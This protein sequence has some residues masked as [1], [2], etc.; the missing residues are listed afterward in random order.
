MKKALKIILSSVSGVIIF[1]IMLPILLSIMLQISAVQNFVVAKVSAKLS[2]IANTKISI[3]HVDIEF[4]T[5]AVLDDIYIQDHR[6]DTMIY[7]KNLKVAINGISFLSGKISLG[8]TTLNGGKVYLYK[9]SSG[10]MNVTE[11]FDNFK[12]TTPNENPPNFRLTATELNLLHTRFKYTD[13]TGEDVDYGIDFKAMD[14]ENITLQAHDI[15]VFNYNIWL[16]MKHLSLNEASGFELDHLSAGRCGVDSSGMYYARVAVETPN[17]TLALDSM[18]FLTINRSWWDWNDFE[19]KMVLS[20]KVRKSHISSQTIGYFTHKQLAHPIEGDLQGALL[21]GPVANMKGVIENLTSGSASVSAQFHIAGL[22]AIDSTVFRVAIEPLKIASNELAPM[23]RKVTGDSLSPIVVSAIE[24]L[25]EVSLV[26]SFD[27]TLHR[28][29]A[30]A[31]LHTAAGQVVATTDM[32]PHGHGQ[33]MRAIVSTTDFELGQM[34]N[35]KKLGKLSLTS[36]VDMLVTPQSPIAFNTQSEIGRIHYGAYDFKRIAINGSFIKQVFKGSVASDDENF[37]FS[38]N[39]I[40][41]FSSLQTSYDIDLDVTK[42]D[43][44]AVGLNK[45]DSISKFSASLSANASGR[46]LDELNGTARIDKILYINHLDTVRASAIDIESIATETLK[47]IDISSGFADISLRGRNSFLEV[48]RYF[49]QSLQRFLPSFP[50][51]TA[52]VTGEKSVDAAA[53]RISKTKTPFPFADGYYQFTVNVKQANNV[54]GIFLPGLEIAQGSSLNFF[55]NPYLDQFNIRAKSEYIQRQNFAVEDLNLEARNIGD[56]LTLFVDADYLTAA[57]IDMPDFSLVGDVCRNVINL[58]GRFKNEQERTTVLVSTTTS[59]ARTAAGVAQMVVDIHPTA[60]TLSGNRWNVR[61]GTLTLDTAGIDLRSIGLYSGSQKLDINGKASASIRDTLN[62][63]MNNFDISPVSIFV[64]SLG[65]HLSGTVGGN[66]RV[67]APFGQLRLFAAMDFLNVHLNDYS[68]GN[69]MLRST[70]DDKNKR[71]NFALGDNLL[72]APISGHYDVA[73]KRYEANFRFPKFDMVLLEPLLAGI[74]TGTRGSADVDL[75]LTGGKGTPSL[76]GK[77]DIGSYSAMVDFTKA[78]YNLGGQ[79][80]VVNNNFFLASTPLSDGGTG[81]GEISAEL[82]SDFFQDLTFDVKASFTNLLAL[83]TK[84]TDNSSFYGK[85][86]GTGRLAIRGTEQ[87]TFINIAASTAD[88]TEFV[89]PL[90]DVATIETADFI[91]FVDPTAKVDST[92]RYR[93]LSQTQQ[94]RGQNELDI[95]INLHVLP[96]AKGL[97][98]FNATMAQEIKGRAQGYLSMHINPSLDIFTIN[99]PLQIQEG[100]YKFTLPPFYKYF[101]IQPGSSMQWS[102]EPANP[103]INLSAVYKVKTSLE[104]LGGTIGGQTTTANIDCGINLSGKLQTP[105]IR[106][107]ITAPSADAETQ[108]LLRNSINTDETLATQFISLV[109]SKSFM[110]D[111]GAAAIGTMGTSFV[112]NTGM[113]FLSNQLSQLISS[114]KVNVRFGY[115]PQSVSTSDEFYA[116]IGGDIIADVL[117]VE[118]DGNYNTGNNPS[119]NSRNPF[120]VDAY[121]TWNINKKGTLKLKGFT[122]TIDRFDETQGLQESGVGV[123]FRQDF[124]DSKDL[125]RRLKE[126]KMQRKEKKKK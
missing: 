95:V 108:N 93:R 25:G 50:D 97:I 123:Y 68:L 98:E 7:A 81:T 52:I 125:K 9:D 31:L 121:L 84:S 72:N 111:M 106:F 122:R 120:T 51:A 117:S 35:N 103:D 96:N 86:Y 66:V 100:D 4:F 46:T 77:V 105:D 40:V 20:A 47:Q 38:A 42:A 109:L 16:S 124:V 89:L 88:N 33:G 91:R 79:V 82:K 2:E 41:D 54:A 34:L 59:F 61:Q 118:V 15:N 110:P 6:G 44:V 8:S 92:R 74:L 107:A 1:I 90:S 11:V 70:I 115:R 112:G 99:G 22:P 80:K 27:G 83:N 113:E 21:F 29:S 23:V 17:S 64:S 26:A 32:A 126:Y 48:A 14:F 49:S 13:A 119:Y 57:G 3:S 114:E 19:H 75:K 36:V 28:F 55:F 101:T 10:L 102:G 94:R 12:P 5:K 73:N 56:S 37:S 45:R 71:I 60:V 87:K 53:E 69:P 39:G 76:N 63:D 116:G 43:L 24:R 78:R 30:R 65:Y 85:A 67:V 58:G 18:N 104:P 62:L